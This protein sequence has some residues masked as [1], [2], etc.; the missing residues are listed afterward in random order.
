MTYAQP[1]QKTDYERIQE[2]NEQNLLNS[3]DPRTIYFI[4][5]FHAD[6]NREF[7]DKMNRS[8]FEQNNKNYRKFRKRAIELTL[9]LSGYPETLG[10][11]VK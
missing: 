3:R 7:Q 6:Q 1:R 8:F 11:L 5:D 9:D 10:E 4:L 2:E